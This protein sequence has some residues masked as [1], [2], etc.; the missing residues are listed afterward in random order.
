MSKRVGI[1]VCLL[2][3]S[4][5]GYAAKDKSKTVKTVIRSWQLLPSTYLADTVAIDTSMVNMPMSDPLNRYSISNIWNGNIVSPVMSRLYF[6]RTD[7]VEDFFGRQFEPFVKTAHQVQFYNTTVPYSRVA[8][9]RGFTQD[10]AENEINLLLTGNLSRRLNVGLEMNYLTSPGHYMSQEGQD[11]NGN[12]FAGYQGK[13]YSIAG[14]FSWSKLKSFDNGG[15]VRDSDLVGSLR[16][17]DIPVRDK[18]M[19][20]YTYMDG[21]LRQQYSITVERQYKEQIEYIN[22]FGERDKKDTIRTEYIPVMS[23][24][25][26]FD[27]DYSDRRFAAPD[28]LGH[29]QNEYSALLNI[30]N[31]LSATF[32]EDFNRLLR[33]GATV[34]ARNECQRYLLRDA[35]R[36][37]V[38]S[39][40]WLNNTFVGASLYKNKGKWVRY[41]VDGNVCLLGYKLGQFEVNGHV[42]GDFA[43]GK[44]QL[45]VQAKAHIKN[46]TPSWYAQ[47]YNSRQYC[48]QNSFGKVYK[49]GVEGE[50]N[51][52]SQWIRPGVKVNFEN[53]QRYIYFDPERGMCQHDGHI[54]MLAVHAKADLTT[55][56]IT[57]ENQVVW[58]HSS[59]A[60]ISVPDI[61]LYH[62]LYYHGWWFKRAMESQIGVDMR[63]YTRYYSPMLMA[64]VGQWYH[65]E[66]IKTG[67]YPVVNVYANF[68]VKLLH[69]KFF[70]QYTNLTHLLKPSNMNYMLMPHYPHN[71]GVI[72]AGLAWHFYR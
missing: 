42:D 8:Y 38:R 17:E 49:Y 51:F 11:Y 72:K 47:H 10:H 50:L 55:P 41:G 53:I 40:H 35:E 9:N 64:S 29:K 66:E 6:D 56:W 39:N 20:D 36:D 28:S 31:T 60:I 62:N 4:L 5:T 14:A 68:Y 13:H 44:N 57:L 21:L 37:S 26:V 61:V 2:L 24:A 18:S 15:L 33:F 67:N 65:Q 12:I 46:E 19:T 69:L 48:W 1:I 58:Q 30:R 34:Y 22:D 7:R 54:Q 59:S 63:Y 70:V 25:H 27:C 23:F 45:T 16:P 52:V 3:A 71:P 43:F 32:E